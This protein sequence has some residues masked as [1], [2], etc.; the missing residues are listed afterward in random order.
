MLGNENG[1]A[2]TS[3]GADDNDRPWQVETDRTACI[4]SGI[5]VASLPAVFVLAEGRSTPLQPHVAA[6]DELIDVVD[7]CPMGAIRVLERATGRVIAPADE[8]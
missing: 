3:A 2:V 7:L 1:G 8:E 5:C 4:G 6:D